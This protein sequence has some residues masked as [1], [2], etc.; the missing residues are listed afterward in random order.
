MNVFHA[1]LELPLFGKTEA[2]LPRD[3]ASKKEGEEG[4]KKWNQRR[5]EDDVHVEL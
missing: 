5:K 4:R 3:L 2:T 1:H